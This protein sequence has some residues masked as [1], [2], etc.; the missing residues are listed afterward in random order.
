MSAQ[1]HP[2]A[3]TGHR[4]GFFSDTGSSYN[5][6]YEQPDSATN[7][8]KRGPRSG[9]SARLAQFLS[10]LKVVPRSNHF[11]R[12]DSPTGTYE[13]RFWARVQKTPN[14]W[15]WTGPRNQYGY[16]VMSF[17]GRGLHVQ[18]IAY[19]IAYGVPDSGLCICHRCDNRAC[20]RPDH[21]FAGT[22]GDNLRDM[23]RKGRHP[24]QGWRQTHCKRGHE[25]TPANTYWK[26]VGGTRSCRACMK[27]RQ[28]V[29]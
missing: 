20:V 5:E 1:R 22:Q 11:A 12:R 18:R 19:A 13:Q 2:G 21:L 4:G 7:V 14:C 10:K 17:G 15:L 9:N 29:A 25:Y 8:D 28:G 6:S 3:I 24:E 27:L 23:V 16:G 26:K